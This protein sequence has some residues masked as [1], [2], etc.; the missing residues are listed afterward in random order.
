MFLW[1]GIRILS[2]IEMFLQRLQYLVWIHVFLQTDGTAGI[3]RKLGF[4]GSILKF[5]CRTNALFLNSNLIWFRLKDSD[6]CKLC[7]DRP[8]KWRFGTFLFRMPD[9]CR[10]QK[11]SC[12]D[13]EHLR[14]NLTDLPHAVQ[15]RFLVGDQVLFWYVG[16][17]LIESS[18]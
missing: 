13:N 4:E 5:L 18:F 12:V 14:V 1:A 3:P 9:S 2:C 7:S 11:L 10:C 15:V 17:W 16:D 8:S 6:D